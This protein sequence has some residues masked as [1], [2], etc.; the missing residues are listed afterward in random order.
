MMMMLTDLL[1]F[2]TE[3]HALEHFPNAAQEIVVDGM[4]LRGVMLQILQILIGGFMA[5]SS[6]AKAHI[7]GPSQSSGRQTKSG[8]TAL[9]VGKLLGLRHSRF[10]WPEG[11]QNKTLQH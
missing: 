7:R 2:P 5:V 9:I 4:S 8:V 3:V 10:M 1:S 6:R 11:Y